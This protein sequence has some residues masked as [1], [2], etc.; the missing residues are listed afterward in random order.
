MKPN[1]S[2]EGSL[3]EPGL[4]A[5]MPTRV[6]RYESFARDR[7]L[8]ATFL[9]RSLLLVGSIALAAIDTADAQKI[10]AGH[11]HSVAVKSDGT[12][13]AWGDNT[14]GQL[15]LGYVASSASVP[16]IPGG[17]AATPTKVLNITGATKVVS[18]HH[19]TM[20]LTSSGTVWAWGWNGGSN[21]GDGTSIDRPTPFQVPSLSGVT[22]IALG[23]YHSAAVTSSGA[24]WIWGFNGY[25]QLGD[26]TNTVRSSPYQLLSS[27]IAS[28]AAGA[29]HTL[30]LKTDGTVVAWGYNYYGQLGDGT[31]TDRSS[32]VTVSGLSGVTA[33]AAGNQF[34]LALK[35]DGTV[36]KWGTNI[37]DATY[38]EALTP[39]QVG[40]LSNITALAAGNEHAIVRK[41]DG[42]LWTWGTNYYGQ[43][44]NGTVT[45]SV[46][47]QLSIA[48]PIDGIAAGQFHSLG[49]DSSGNIWSWGLNDRNQLGDVSDRTRFVPEQISGEA[50]VKSMASGWSH[51]L[52]VKQDGSIE[53]T[54]INE[55]GQLGLG[56][57]LV[58]DLFTPISGTSGFVQAS[59]NNFTS[60]ARKTDGTIWAWGNNYYGN[61]GDNTT[62]QRMTPVQ[63]AGISGAISVSAGYHHSI[64]LKSD[65]T[66]WTWG[67]NYAGQVGNGT[68]T[69]RLVPAALTTLSGITAIAAGG[70][71]SLALKSDGTV[72]AWGSNGDGSVGD[73]SFS[74]RLSPVQVSGL[75]NVVAVAAGSFYSVALKSDGTAWA[76][77]SGANGTLGTGST[78][79]QNVPVRV[80]GTGFSNVTGI[81]A[82]RSHAFARKSDGTVWAWGYNGGGQL[83]DGTR[84]NRSLPVQIHG[85]N[86]STAISAGSNSTLALKADGTL[87]GWGFGL[88]GELSEGFSRLQPS[89]SQVFG[90]NLAGT[91]P[92][93]TITSPSAGTLVPVGTAAEVS[94]SVTPGSGTVS[95]VFYFSRGIPLGERNSSPFSFS[96]TPTTWGRFEIN[97]IALNSSGVYSKPASIWISATS[98]DVD[99]DGLSDVWETTHFGGIGVYGAL[100]DPDGDGLTNLQEF[101]AGAD[102]NSSDGDGDGLPDA[103][104]LQYFNSLGYDGNDDPDGD[105]VSNAD[106]LAQSTDPSSAADGNSNG[107]PDDWE[108]AQAGNFSA[109]PPVLGRS[110]LPSHAT[111][112]NIILWNDT[113]ATVSYTASV[114]GNVVTGYGAMDSLTGGSVYA[115]DEISV[116]GTRLATISNADDASQAVAI[117][118]FTF[119][120]GTARSQVFVSS[121]GLLTFG[122]ADSS[123]SNYEIPSTSAPAYSIAAFWDDLDTRTTGDIYS[124]L[125]SNRLIIQFQN[126]GRR[127]G[128]GTYTFQ[129]VLHSD[130]RVDLRYKSMTGVVND[131]TVGLQKDAGGDG[132][133]V[134]YNA[135]YLVNN[136]AV[137]IT[138]VRE[139]F[140]LGSLTGSVVPGATAALPGQ[141]RSFNFI[142]GIHEADV[143][144]SHNAAGGSPLAVTAELT[145]L[146]RPA[147]ISITSPADGSPAMQGTYLS[148]QTTATDPDGLEKVE[149]YD[150]ATKL[151]E[152][153]A[154]P[155]LDDYSFYWYLTENGARSL[156]TRAIDIY[157]GETVSAA[158]LVNVAADSDFDGMPDSWE[159]TNGFN[160]ND[161]GDSSADADGDGYTNLEEYQLGKNP[162]VLEDTDSDGMPDGWEYHNGTNINV[163]DGG[164]DPDNDG[165]T[166]LQE[167]QHGTNPRTFDTD[168]DLLPDLY[169]IQHGLNPLVQSGDD[170]EE[171]DGL[172][173]LEEFLH[174]TDPNNA[175]TDGDGVSDGVEVAQGSDPNNPAD[176]GNPPPDPL[177]TL[178]FKVGG[179]YASWRME[180]K[181][182]GPRDTR[183]LLVVSP[184]PG[185]WET[186]SHKL[187]KNNKYEITMHHTGSR[188]ED[189]P[190]WYCW[191]GQIDA[192]P[193][194][195]T[196]N[197]LPDHQ[198]GARNNDGK[199][200][201][202]KDHWI[203]DNREGLLT[204]HLHSKG[205]N[206][207]AGKKAI[208][209]PVILEVNET[210]KETDDLVPVSGGTDEDLATDFSVEVSGISGLTAAL[211]LKDSNGD[212]KFKDTTLTL[213]DGVK[214]KTK[215]WGI[216]P[217][218]ARDTTFIKATIK[219][220][221]EEI[222]VVEEDVTVFKGVKIEF[223][224]KFYINVDTREF[225][226]R[227]WD[228]RVDP[229]P[230]TKGSLTGSMI[231]M[232]GD[233]GATPTPAA[234]A[235]YKKA[236][237]QCL[238]FGYQS[239]ISFNDGDNSVI[240]L[241]KPW[242][243]PLDVKV[244]KAYS[245]SPSFE[246]PE[247]IVVNQKVKLKKGVLDGLPDGQEQLLDPQ[248]EVTSYFTLNNTSVTTRIAGQTAVAPSVTAA[249]IQAQIL[250]EMGKGYDELLNYMNTRPGAYA[251]FSGQRFEWKNDS[252]EVQK[253]ASIKNSFAAKALKGEH[254]KGT[255]VEAKWIFR[256]WNEFKF[257]GNLEGAV[258]ETK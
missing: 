42:T 40:S 123:Y 200:F 233:I 223:G 47:Q 207:V 132:V 82:G 90:F 227:P 65:G 144:I 27:G 130:G 61:L 232:N 94:V 85:A 76:W 166:N 211:S 159:I 214:S 92:T 43:L 193:G 15:G 224:G 3:H 8:T 55:I 197:T 25:G 86:W 199:F 4:P 202:I 170:D 50:L 165:L 125:E 247:E 81:M 242:K 103:W 177:E 182:L 231:Y 84:T 1:V 249:N 5:A 154:Y 69:Q 160:P 21:L 83:G 246:L 10:G 100:D 80:G 254:E 91:P 184:A 230:N 234:L 6:A 93:V 112:G 26:G 52:I 118:G 97:A 147:T 51:N 164:L 219:L 145:V 176:G 128:T 244:A 115:W 183:T 134:V 185:T 221:A 28:V 41:N 117:T 88:D 195:E 35:S 206:H 151:G 180:I 114:T 225:A 73:G 196:F 137:R 131:A 142:P 191:E 161:S 138:P 153:T 218:S 172:T 77:G 210:A 243:G 14:F 163:P 58:R 120:F 37:G 209:A 256:D 70:E 7:N 13:W 187:W 228:G 12:V 67:G 152:A 235:A 108:L 135:P 156:T 38:S 29:S 157:G 126:V 45:Q 189:D 181:S 106:E 16:L 208:L 31:R 24:L 201:V 222:G 110:I 44:G 53:S 133:A 11:M 71:H 124:K 72:W 75:T 229:K 79:R 17:A 173:N 23:D 149:F 236:V 240:P 105:G 9:R 64:A 34:S 119:P 139:F 238:S 66:V 169:E 49:L 113:G 2:R 111:A 257:V 213:T 186:K 258:I 18:N 179:D 60:L 212:L 116:T 216:S 226:R 241:Y 78:V 245:K 143:S 175:D 56:D 136:L 39:V 48:V 204:S 89:P 140:S 98:D 146:N 129:V 96:Y 57:L 127:S 33:V 171:P 59:A 167:Y 251:G 46:P 54:G 19:Q 239:A 248:I 68:L 74:N 237:D 99:N 168:G 252:F 253:G 150:G 104:E 121:N 36:W 62:T 162:H 155:G 95:K 190:P 32:P 215:L 198:I 20:A 174:K 109:W 250:A 194:L 101:Q 148:I 217:S 203:V 107:L 87:L 141:F 220:G 205:V 22:T 102:P 63:S 188:P 122:A 192:K 30:A 158:V 178:E 255:K